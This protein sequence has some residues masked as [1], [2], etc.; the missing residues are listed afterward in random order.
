[1]HFQIENT[2]ELREKGKL[3]RK[4]R[5]LQRVLPSYE[6]AIGGCNSGPVDV[7]CLNFDYFPDSADIDI[8]VHAKVKDEDLID[9]RK[10]E[11]IGVKNPGETY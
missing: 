1:M 3:F 7:D 5:E 4:S 8:S 10:E 2:N 11:N 6:L 9:P